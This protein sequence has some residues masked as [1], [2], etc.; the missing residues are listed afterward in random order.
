MEL[1][2]GGGQRRRQGRTRNAEADSLRCH[3]RWLDICDQ[4]PER[5]EAAAGVPRHGEWGGAK[6]K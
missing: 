1:S 3:S 2:G 6:R 5:P 4:M